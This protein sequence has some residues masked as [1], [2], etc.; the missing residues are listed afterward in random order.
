MSLKGGSTAHTRRC[1]RCSQSV[2]RSVAQLLEHLH[3]VV[4]VVQ[5]PAVIGN[6]DHDLVTEI[7][8][9]DLTNDCA[10]RGFSDGEDD[11]DEDDDDDGEDAERLF[12]SESSVSPW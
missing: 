1:I 12:H 7:N 4:H 5:V 10:F 3:N 9:L 8:S 2:R 11:D 6:G